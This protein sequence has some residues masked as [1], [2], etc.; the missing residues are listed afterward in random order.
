[1]TKCEP[2]VAGAEDGLDANGYG[3][4]ECIAYGDAVE[5]WG[6]DAENLEG[7]A[8]ESEAFANHSGVPGIIALP[9]GVTDIRSGGAATGL[10]VFGIDEAA[11]NG[12][13][14]KD[15]KEIAG[16][17]KSLGEADF[18]AVCEI[19]FLARP[20]GDFGE[21]FLALA[22]LFTHREAELGL[23]AGKLAGTPFAVCN[24]DRLRLPED[25]DRH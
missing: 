24:H 14:T 1:M 3:D 6:R 18:A 16:N 15:V 10:V 7:I 23:L 21:S 13:N 11:E 8:I 25:L 17:A 2:V 20:G 4:V 5:T 9:E 19:E 22:D 12:L